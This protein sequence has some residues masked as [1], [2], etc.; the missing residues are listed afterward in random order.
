MLNSLLSQLTNIYFL[1]SLPFQICYSLPKVSKDW[2]NK[3]D[4]NVIHK[5]SRPS[6]PTNWERSDIPRCNPRLKSMGSTQVDIVAASVEGGNL[7][8][9]GSFRLNAYFSLAGW[10]APLEVE[11]IKQKHRTRLLLVLCNNGKRRRK[12]IWSRTGIC[13]IYL[14]FVFF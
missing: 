9:M 5:F 14:V 11:K 6:E 10:K 8:S 3:L 12:C 13:F 4:I 7:K 1:F 2:N